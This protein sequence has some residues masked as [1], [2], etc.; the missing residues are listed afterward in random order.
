MLGYLVFVCAGLNYS[1]PYSISIRVS[2]YC[3]DEDGARECRSKARSRPKCY[4]IE[5]ENWNED[6]DHTRSA[7]YQLSL[8]QFTFLSF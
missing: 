6:L 7:Y 4:T 8:F 3:E 2:L 5:A 1:H